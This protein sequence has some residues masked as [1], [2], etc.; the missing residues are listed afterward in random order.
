MHTYKGPVY[1]DKPR[2]NRN[3][4]TGT[5]VTLCNIFEVICSLKSVYFSCSSS[6]QYI[7]IP[8]PTPESPTALRVFS[9]YLSSDSKD[10]PQASFDCIHQ[11]VA[12]DGREQLEGQGIIQDK[13]TVCA[14]DDSY[15]MTRERMSQVEKDSWSRAAIEI[16][17]GATHPSEDIDGRRR[18]GEEEER[19]RG[20]E[21]E[22]SGGMMHLQVLIGG[23]AKK[24]F[25]LGERDSMSS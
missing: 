20:G 12:S 21:E 2:E 5:R 14:T 6:T 10:Q 24:L 3:T 8:A 9:F 13:I 18:G 11:Y 15:Q 4:R 16:K 23:G 1:T 22:H 17:P 25:E 7:K 19:R